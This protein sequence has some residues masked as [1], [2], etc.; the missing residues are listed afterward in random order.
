VVVTSVHNVGNKKMKRLGLYLGAV[1][2]VALFVLAGCSGDTTSSSSDS[3]ASNPAPT[4]TAPTPSPTPAPTPTPPTP[5]PTGAYYFSD[6]QSGAQAGCT[7]GD[8]TNNGHTPGT[9]RQNLTGFDVNAVPA[10]TQLLFSRGGAW[11]NF[12][13]TLRNLYATPTQPI[14]FDSYTPAWGG[15][16]LPW[17]K[18]SHF[19]GFEFGRYNDT[20]NDGGYIVRNLKL[21]GENVGDWGAWLRTTTR[22]VTL[23]NLEITGFEIAVHA[24]NEGATGNTAFALRNSNIHHNS[25]MGLLGAAYDSVIEGNVFANN[26][27]SGS[28]FNHA[29]YLGSGSRESR[30]VTVRNNTF[31]NNS[32]VNGVCTGGNVTVHGQWDGLLF[33]NNRIEQVESTGGCYGF[34]I[35]TGYTTAEWFRNVVVRNNTIVNLG[36]CAVCVDAAPGIVIENNNIFKQW[37]TYH[38]AVVIAGDAKT[39]GDAED[40]GA[41]IRNNTVYLSQAVGFNEAIAIRAHSGTDIQVVSNLIYNGAGSQPTHQCFGHTALSN[42]AAFR[43]NLC[44]HAGGNGAWSA[45]YATLAGAQAVGFDIDGLSS[46]PQFAAVPSSGNNWDD[47]LNAA[48]PAVNAGHATLSS[49][50]DRLSVPRVTPDI[51]AREHQ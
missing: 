16:A 15:S 31:T 1:M 6:C 17:L 27:F 39:G 40:T 44:H 49:S 33:E 2:F 28:A 22:N 34:S 50:H 23:E 10:G 12:R 38:A 43:N 26:N 8:N 18:V 20:E 25:G 21:D 19:V 37:P 41:I 7:P 35:T 14:V 13:V 46:D 36:N 5:S 47:L 3:P 30:N 42:F 51:G 24:V 32:T 45:S 48:S 11:T 9:A 29:I 4:P